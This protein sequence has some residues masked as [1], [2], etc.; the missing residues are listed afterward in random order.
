MNPFEKTRLQSNL[1]VPPHDAAEHKEY[2]E[3]RLGGG[4]PN[5]NLERY[6]NNDRKVLSYNIMWND[7]SYDGGLKFYTLNYFLSDG[8]VRIKS[9]RIGGGERN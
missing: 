9:Y 4:H 2:I 7:T 6:M 8:T 1:K 3:V 5:R